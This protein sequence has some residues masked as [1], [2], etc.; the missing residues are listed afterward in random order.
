MQWDF[1]LISQDNSDSDIY[2]INLSIKIIKANN[3]QYTAYYACLQELMGA[4]QVTFI[5]LQ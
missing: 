4:R 5:F 2:S 3:S 1:K